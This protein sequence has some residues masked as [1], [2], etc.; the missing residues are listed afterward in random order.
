MLTVWCYREFY[1]ANS[2]I[3]WMEVPDGR[4]W[5]ENMRSTPAQQRG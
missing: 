5:Q 2:S 3:Q 1:G 4:G